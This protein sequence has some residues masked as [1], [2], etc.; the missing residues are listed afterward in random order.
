MTHTNDTTGTDKPNGNCPVHL[1]AW[2]NLALQTKG[3]LRR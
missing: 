1:L 3:N 2:G